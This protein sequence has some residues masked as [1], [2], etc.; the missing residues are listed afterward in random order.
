LKLITDG[1]GCFVIYHRNIL[2][3]HG[4]KELFNFLF[5]VSGLYI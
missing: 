4:G 3:Q 2:R 1:L 5:K